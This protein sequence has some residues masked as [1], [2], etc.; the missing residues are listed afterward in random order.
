M[1]AIR[2]RKDQNG[3]VS[4]QAQVRIQGYPPQSKTFLR[5]TDAKQWAIQT[6]T[7]IRTGMTIRKSTASKHTVREMLER[8]RD[9]VLID[10]ANGGKDHKTH[11]AWWIDELGHYALSEVTTDLVTRSMDKLKKSK[12]RLGKSPAPATVLR[13]LM[14]LS[15]AFNVAR[16]QWNWCESSPVENV[17]RPKV[18][19]ERTRYLTDVEREALLQACKNSPNADLYLV[20]LLAISTGMRKGEIMGMRWQD[21]HTA[22]DQSF[23]R[24]HLTNTKNDKARSVLLTSPALELLEERRIKLIDSLQAKAATGLIFPSAVNADQPV[25][26]RKPWGSA[27]QAAGV[28]GFRFHDLR[29]TTASYLAM[30]GASLLSIS[31]VL[32]HQTTKMTERYSHLATSHID[33]VVRSMNAKKFG[34]AVTSTATEIAPKAPPNSAQENN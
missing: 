13:Y 27:L 6:E 4:Y 5:K 17:Q 16:K 25:D 34:P 18:K 15:H 31:K 20:V 21:I 3:K 1:A 8:Y 19:N 10:K 33:E 23:T 29:H 11:I 28:D 7:E 14:A 30:N 9:N 2:E 22:P 24:V 26:L 12:T 32:G